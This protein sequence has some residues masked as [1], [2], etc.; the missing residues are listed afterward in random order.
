MEVWKR[1]LA[2]RKI[3]KLSEKMRRKPSEASV[4]FRRISLKAEKLYY[5]L[6]SKIYR[7]GENV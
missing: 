1:K 3:K 7:R 6:V 2:R 4:K 5:K